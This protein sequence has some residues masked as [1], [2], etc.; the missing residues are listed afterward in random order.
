MAEH[1]AAAV[2]RQDHL[3]RLRKAQLDLQNLGDDADKAFLSS[4]TVQVCISFQ[5]RINDITDQ[6]YPNG[7]W[8]HHIEPLPTICRTLGRMY[9]DLHCVVGLEFF[10]KGVLYLRERYGPSWVLHLEHI[11]KFMFFLAQADDDSIKWTAAARAKDLL[12]RVNMRDV[13]RGYLCLACVDSK[14][15]FG[16]SSA[17]TRAMHDFA[18]HSID[19]YLDPKIDTDEFRK[20]F[21]ISQ[22]RILKWAS[23]NPD[24]ALALPSRER[25][26]E[27]R[28]DIAMVWADK[29]PR[30][31]WPR[32][33]KTVKMG[34]SGQGRAKK[35]LENEVSEA[36][37][38][39]ES[40]ELGG[41][42]QTK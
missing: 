6:G 20:R 14:F 12:Q 8:P 38:A 19:C 24:R 10:L 2:N 39:I 29:V 41:G 37:R 9:R 30:I 15:T 31:E 5:D 42:A 11:V 40:M 26:A 33:T 22:E 18:G 16:L 1:V 28:R 17:Y 7:N 32:K 23:V 35:D 21:R 36:V 27:L 4:R 25:V 3:A 34:D 13:A